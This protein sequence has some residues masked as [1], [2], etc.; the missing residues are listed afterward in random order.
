M[1]TS[2]IDKKGF[3][4]VDMLNHIAKCFTYSQ[5]LF[6]LVGELFLGRLVEIK[7]KLNKN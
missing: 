5:E 2:D 4:T 7:K 1:E 3:A 6:K